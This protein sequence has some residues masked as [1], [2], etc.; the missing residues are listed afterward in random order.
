MIAQLD[1]K[2]EEETERALAK[3]A[4][5]QNARRNL[6]LSSQSS[7]QQQETDYVYDEDTSGRMLQQRFERF[8]DEDYYL[9]DE[10]LEDVDLDLIME[11]DEDDF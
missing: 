6:L 11:E 5:M 10:Q 8:R 7:Q 2:E 4:D 9:D 1:I 3:L